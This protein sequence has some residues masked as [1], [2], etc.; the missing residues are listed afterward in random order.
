MDVTY[1]QCVAIVCTCKIYF[2]AMSE[3]TFEI[4]TSRICVQFYELIFLC[5]IYYTNVIVAHYI[6][7]NL[8]P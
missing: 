6:Y 5:G 4:V 8:C 7:V 2:V 3:H 1:L